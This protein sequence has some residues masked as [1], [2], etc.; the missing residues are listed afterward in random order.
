MKLTITEDEHRQ[1]WNEAVYRH[2]SDPREQE[3]LLALY[4]EQGPDHVP[5]QPEGS[6][7]KGFM[8]ATFV[9]SCVGIAALA[10]EWIRSL[11]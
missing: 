4:D 1:A 3:I 5:Q 10:I 9:V 2:T 8:G 7:I 11:L 6:P